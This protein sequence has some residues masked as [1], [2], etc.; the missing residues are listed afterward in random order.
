MNHLEVRMSSWTTITLLLQQNVGRNPVTTSGDDRTQERRSGAPKNLCPPQWV[1]D[2]TQLLQFDT[3]I[4][5]P[6][7]SKYYNLSAYLLPLS[8][9]TLRGSRVVCLAKECRRKKEGKVARKSGFVEFGQSQGL[10]L[11]NI[12][13]GASLESTTAP[14]HQVGQKR[15]RVV[16]G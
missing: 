12:S 4:S 10:A 7:G 8:E 13:L 2:G 5:H 9:G 14:H 15:R 16:R 3:C 6:R 11:E 1:W